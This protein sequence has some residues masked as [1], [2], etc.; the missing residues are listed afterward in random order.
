[1]NTEIPMD[2]VEVADLPPADLHDCLRCDG[3][4]GIQIEWNPWVGAIYDACP[5]CD[6][7]GQ[8]TPLGG[9]A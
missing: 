3:T 5:S 7:S 2:P 4:G 8:A 6:G 9:A 1:M